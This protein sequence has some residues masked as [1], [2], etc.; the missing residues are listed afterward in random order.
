MKDLLQFFRIVPP[1]PRM[2]TLLFGAVTT[3]AIALVTIDPSFASGALNAVLVLQVFAASS[4]FAGYARRGYYDIL[5]TQG[6][7]RLRIAVAHWLV[8]IAPGLACWLVLAAAESSMRHGFSV[9]A[10]ASGTIVAMLIVSTT[11]W[12]ITVPLPRFAGAIGWVVVVVMGAAVTGA[13]DV[14]APVQILVYPLHLIGRTVAGRGIE[15]APAL[16]LAAAS[17]A[18]ALVWVDRTDVPLEAAQ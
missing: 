14:P 4:G 18:V 17:M 9:A 13:Y 5:L 15:V 10:T 6:V 2:I 16:V 12:A 11:A 7:S 1:V 3:G 8:S